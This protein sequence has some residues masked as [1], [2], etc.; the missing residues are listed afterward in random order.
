MKITKL[1][2][3]TLLCALI[4]GVSYAATENDVPEAKSN[5]TSSAK[6]IDAKDIDTQMGINNSSDEN[7]KSRLS[8]ATGGRVQ[9]VVP[10]RKG[11]VSTNVKPIPTD[12]NTDINS[13]TGTIKNDVILIK[14]PE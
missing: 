2:S 13:P 7:A 1:L 6:P 14:K 11:S 9:K 4:S 5:K 8:E 10:F 3:A 12:Q